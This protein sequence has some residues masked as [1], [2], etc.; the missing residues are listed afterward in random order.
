MK[1]SAKLIS[2]LHKNATSHEGA[3]LRKEEGYTYLGRN[4]SGSRVPVKLLLETQNKVMLRLLPFWKGNVP[5]SWL[6]YPWI[7]TRLDSL[8]IDVGKLPVSWLS[9]NRKYSRDCRLPILSGILPLKLFPERTR[10][11]ATTYQC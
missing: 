11:A 10:M 5:V 8:S 3:T 2:S 7:S 6:S 9:A 1:N 4:V